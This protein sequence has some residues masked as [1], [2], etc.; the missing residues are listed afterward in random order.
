MNTDKMTGDMPQAGVRVNKYISSAGLCSRREADRLIA[1]GRVLVDSVPASPGTRVLPGQTVC[2]DGRIIP[3]DDL[4]EPVMYAVN[5]PAGV[6][7]SDVRQGNAPILSDI[8]DLPERVFYVG[9]LD[10]DSEGLLLLTNQGD[11][12]NEMMRARNRHEK[13][14]EV[15]VDRPLTPE[16]LRVMAGGVFLPELD[17]TTRKCKVSRTGTDSFRIV[18]TQGLNRQIRRMCA[19]LGYEVRSLRRIRIMQ[20][21]LGSLSPGQIRELTQEEMA[22]LRQ[23][24]YRK[25]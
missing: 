13:E 18:L 3:S 19:A 4:P 10:K 9:R 7:C 23:Q 15:T 12:A 2:V 1:T 11:L 14:Y 16:F 5:K 24:T 21:M 17:V 22:L 6:I 20:I 8:L 25:T